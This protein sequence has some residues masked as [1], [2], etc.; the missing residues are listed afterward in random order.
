VSI[1]SWAAMILAA[2][3]GTRLEPLTHELPKPLCPIGGAAPID[4]TI[5]ALASAGASR[6]VVNAFHLAEAYDAAFVVRQPVPVDVVREVDLLGTAGGVANARHLLGDGDVVIWNGD[7]VAEV[8]LAEL[9]ATRR[10]TDAHAV[11]ALR[12]AAAGEGAVGVDATGRVV[13]LRSS[14]R[15]PEDR[16]GHYAGI[17]VLSARC[18]AGLPSPGCLVGD[19]WI[20]TLLGGGPDEGRILTL[21][22][23]GP[24]RDIGTIDE[25]LAANLQAVTA[26]GGSIVAASATVASGVTVDRCVIGEGARVEGEGTLREVVV[27]PGAVATA[28]LQTAVVT[29]RNVARGG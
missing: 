5:A 12:P 9:V 25:Y 24:F 14:R 21:P 1:G 27:W 10:A 22:Y 26:H 15:A 28:P 17:A 29:P 6:V 13:R 3:R 11:L 7:I 23:R 18:V 19:A 4:R 2:G 8:D 16:G 20:P